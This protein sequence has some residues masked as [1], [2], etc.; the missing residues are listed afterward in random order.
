M[1][2]TCHAHQKV[3]IMQNGKHTSSLFL[4]LLRSFGSAPHSLLVFLF[5]SAAM[6]VLN[7]NADKHV[8]HKEAHQENESN[9]VEEPPLRIVLYWLEINK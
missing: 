6:E 7:H 5:L 9:E 1:R 8:E 2:A 3:M 4:H